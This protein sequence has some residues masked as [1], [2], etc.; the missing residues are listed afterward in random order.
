[1]ISSNVIMEKRENNSHWMISFKE[2][3][4]LSISSA[5]KIEDY[6]DR[7][8]SVNLS[9]FNYCPVCGKKIELNKLN[10]KNKNYEI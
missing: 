4:E 2:L 1:M 3:K 6:V 5:Y 9:R 7:R 8:K 10:K